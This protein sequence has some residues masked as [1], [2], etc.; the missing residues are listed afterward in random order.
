MQKLS[1]TSMTTIITVVQRIDSFCHCFHLPL[2]QK[3]RKKEKHF[4]FIYISSVVVIQIDNTQRCQIEC[5]YH[6]MS[7]MIAWGKNHFSI[8]LFR[9]N[10]LKSFQNGIDPNQPVAQRLYRFK[11]NLSYCT[12][13]GNKS[14]FDGNAIKSIFF[15]H[16]KF[17]STTKAIHWVKVAVLTFAVEKGKEENK[18]I[19]FHSIIVLSARL[20]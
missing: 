15:F 2:V 20:A 6:F 19:R 14:G 10:E 5:L 17:Q 9:E 3:K 13:N 11:W 16:A 4:S 18:I 8:T 7:L 12:V 1:C